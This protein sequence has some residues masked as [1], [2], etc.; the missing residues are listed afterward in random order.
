MFLINFLLTKT[1][2]YVKR[3]KIQSVKVKDVV[4]GRPRSS[5]HWQ[6]GHLAWMRCGCVAVS[7]ECPASG[8]HC[9]SGSL[10]VRACQGPLLT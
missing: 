2:A 8:K 6:P 5:S 3:G 1:L 9:S 4:K 7:P 10:G